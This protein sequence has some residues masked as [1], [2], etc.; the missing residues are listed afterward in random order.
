MKAS[1]GEKNLTSYLTNCKKKVKYI[2][3]NKQFPY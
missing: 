1:L 2:Q 3:A